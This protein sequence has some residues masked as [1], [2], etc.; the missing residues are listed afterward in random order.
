MPYALRESGM[1]LAL[2]ASA[3][4]RGSRWSSNPF[5]NTGP[6]VRCAEGAAIEEDMK[7]LWRALVMAPAIAL[8]AA[9]ASVGGGPGGTVTNGGAPTNQTAGRPSEIWPMKVREHVHLWL[10]GFAMLQEE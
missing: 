9:C 8:L 4:V 5:N 3:V 7:R 6:G 10:H 1:A 2:P